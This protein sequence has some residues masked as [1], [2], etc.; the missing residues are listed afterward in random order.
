MTLITQRD[1]SPPQVDRRLVTLAAK[2]ERV[3]LFDVTLVFGVEQ[4]VGI[5][6]GRE[7]PNP[8]KVDSET[9]DRFMSKTE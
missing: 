6:A 5:F 9:V 4:F 3:V 8:R 2:A 7:K 1:L